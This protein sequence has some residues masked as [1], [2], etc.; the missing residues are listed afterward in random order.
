YGLLTKHKVNDKY[1]PFVAVIS[2]IICY[3]INIYLNL[4][5]ELLII[6]G[7]ISFIAMDIIRKGKY[8]W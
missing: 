3:F 4:G 1:V 2:P 8:Y 7:L 6:N 5:F